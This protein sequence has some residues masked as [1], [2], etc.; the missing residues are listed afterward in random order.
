MSERI[1]M[2]IRGDQVELRGYVDGL[3]TAEEVSRSLEHMDVMVVAS[4]AADDYAPWA[5]LERLIAK[6]ATQV[7]ITA[8]RG[9]APPRVSGYDTH[10]EA[11]LTA[12]EYDALREVQSR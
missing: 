1:R 6:L 11:E 9:L 12:E 3:G 5:V 10:G 4:L 2:T 7:E 8:P